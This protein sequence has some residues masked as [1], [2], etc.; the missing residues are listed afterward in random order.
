MAAVRDRLAKDPAELWELA[1][2][3]LAAGEAPD[4]EIRALIAAEYG[5]RSIA[6]PRLF[7]GKANAA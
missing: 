4:D 2:A 5:R 6:L 7:R 1:Q 3:L